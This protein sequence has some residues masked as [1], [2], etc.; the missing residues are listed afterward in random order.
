MP[1]AGLGPESPCSSL[2]VRVYA[3][4]PRA[5]GRIRPEASPSCGSL[6]RVE[7]T[8]SAGG[9]GSEQ[10]GCAS[11]PPC[12]C[13]NFSTGGTQDGRLWGRGLGSGSFPLFAPCLVVPA[14]ARSWG[15]QGRLVACLHAWWRGTV[16]SGSQTSPLDP[17]HQR[18]FSRVLSPL[19]GGRPDW[20]DVWSS[21][22]ATWAVSLPGLCLPHQY[23]EHK[24]GCSNET[25]F[26]NS[27]FL[28]SPFCLFLLLPLL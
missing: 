24:A 11:A 4:K 18:V 15:P 23:H 12:V 28:F 16:N 13:V 21:L 9:Q 2:S 6:C 25:M 19:E 10:R 22:P 1:S 5:A 20:V 17:A 8:E 27:V 3:C 7:R 14:L 26:I